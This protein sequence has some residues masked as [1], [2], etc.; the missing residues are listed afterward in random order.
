MSEPETDPRTAAAKPH[1]DNPMTPAVL[2]S[3]VAALVNDKAGVRSDELPLGDRLND[4]NSPRRPVRRSW[5]LSV[6][7]WCVTLGLFVVAVLRMFRHDATVSLTWLNAFTLY[8]YLPAYLALVFAVWTRRWWLATASAAVVACHLTWLAPDFRPATPYVSPILDAADAPQ[9]IRIFYLNVH[10]SNRNLEGV[11]AEARR[12]NSDVIVLAEMQRWW[13]HEFIDKNPLKEYPYGTNLQH[14]NAGDIGVFSRLPIRRMQQI[15]AETRTGIV[16]DVA[17]G[18]T[19]LRLFALHS[20]R[21]MLHMVDDYYKF[22]QEIEPIL[23]EQRGP[24]VVLGD[25]N[26]TQHSRVYE[27]LEADG[28]RSAHEDRGRGYATTWPNGRQPLPPI[29]I[30]QAFLSPEVECVSIEEGVGP[31]SDHKPLIVDLRVHHPVSAGVA[32]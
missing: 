3:R 21:P 22:W 12:A 2:A 29:R 27:Q 8:L 15:P 17:L 10:A 11:L 6:L 5:L 19:T 30:D 25:F 23:A 16:A 4:S 28:L 13:W 18:A 7:A 1:D 24:L 9:S 20:P 32:R 31:G 26:A 14:R